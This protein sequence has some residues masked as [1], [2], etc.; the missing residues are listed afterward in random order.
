MEKNHHSDAELFEQLGLDSSD[1]Q[2]N[3]F[4]QTHRPLH[5]DIKISEAPFW[6]KAQA[7]FLREQM[8]LDADW[9]VAIDR[10]N[11]RLR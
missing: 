1:T 6:S 10:L 8:T 7:K 4:I 3:R 5:P 9:V 11:L 2:I